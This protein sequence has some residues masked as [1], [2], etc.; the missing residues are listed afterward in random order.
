LHRPGDHVLWGDALS[1]AAD[2]LVATRSFY[3][4]IVDSCHPRRTQGIPQHQGV[5]FFATS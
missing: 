4:V 5:L 1:L 3:M 2:G